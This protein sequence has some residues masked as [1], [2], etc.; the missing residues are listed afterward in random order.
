MTKTA[1]DNR[2]RTRS[3]SH[4][5]FPLVAMEKWAQIVKMTGDH[6]QPEP[7]T[8]HTGSGDYSHGN[9]S[10]EDEQL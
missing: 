3:S 2:Y 5:S 9:G 10:T 4:T 1:L 6:N 7:K 8:T